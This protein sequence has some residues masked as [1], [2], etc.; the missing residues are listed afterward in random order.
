METI[1][2]SDDLVA[3][4]DQ[5]SH[6][7]CSIVG[8]V[9]RACRKRAA[10]VSRHDVDAACALPVD[11]YAATEP[12]L[13]EKRNI[14]FRIAQAGN[15]ER[16]I[17]PSVRRAQ[18][19]QHEP[20]VWNADDLEGAIANILLD[21]DRLRNVFHPNV[22]SRSLFGSQA[23]HQ[24]DYPGKRSTISR[25]D[26]AVACSDIS[27]VRP[28]TAPCGELADNRYLPTPTSSKRNPP[29]VSTAAAFRPSPSF[30][31]TSQKSCSLMTRTDRSQPHPPRRR[32]TVRQ[33]ETAGHNPAVLQADFSGSPALAWTRTVLGA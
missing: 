14:H 8:C 25:T 18:G 17:D 2:S 28:A 21:L 15:F 33:N 23:C 3:P 4:V 29:S 19:V 6:L 13:A 31:R 11:Q 9:V 5:P 24:P 10:V 1:A 27:I 7:V 20:A 12:R 30:S 32:R 16:C 22:Q 26:S